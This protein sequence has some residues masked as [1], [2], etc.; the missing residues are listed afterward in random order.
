MNDVNPK[1]PDQKYVLPPPADK[2]N[3]WPEQIG[4]LEVI[5]GTGTGINTIE[6]LAAAVHPNAAPITE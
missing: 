4:L 1:G 2:L 5:V 3:V 6:A